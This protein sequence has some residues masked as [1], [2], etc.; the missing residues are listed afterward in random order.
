MQGTWDGTYTD[1]EK[2]ITV[3][4]WRGGAPMVGKEYTVTLDVDGAWSHVW[5][6]LPLFVDGK[7]AEYTVRVTNIGDV[8]YDAN[9]PGIDDGYEDYDITFDKNR[10]KK[11]ADGAYDHISGYWKDS[12][13]E[14]VFAD[15]VLI[16]FNIETVSG[17]LTLRKVSD[18]VNGKP[19]AGVKFALYSDVNRANVVEVAVS[20]GNGEVEF[21]SKLAAGTYYLKETEALDGYALD[22]TVYMVR[23]HAGIAT[24]TAVGGDGTAVHTVV[25][26]TSQ[27]LTIEKVNQSGTYV[28]GAKFSLTRTGDYDGGE[29]GRN[30]SPVYTSDEH[31]K[32]VI[33]GL[34]RGTYVLKEITAPNGY[35]PLEDDFEFIVADGEIFLPTGTTAPEEWRL[36]DSRTGGYTLTVVNQ[37]LYVFPTTGGVGIYAPIA[38]GAALMCMSAV[39]IIKRKRETA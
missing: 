10:Y 6:N 1:E 39:L 2:P 9:I 38:L 19:L 16:H 15:H 17:K 30:D 14:D 31:G 27:T 23:V 20:G 35:K 18:T 34:E 25:N 33:P 26:E 12:N 5:E 7:L 21:A 29:G 22:N 8:A 13:G 36:E 28:S 11:G 24:V 32:I 37:V 3:Q 4:L